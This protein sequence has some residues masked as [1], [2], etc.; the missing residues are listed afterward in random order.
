VTSRK[1]APQLPN[2]PT[3][4]EAGIPDFEATSW[5]AF[6]Y[7]TGTPRPIVDKLHSEVLKVVRLTDVKAT[8]DAQAFEVVGLGPDKFPEFVHSET[9][10]YERV[11]REAKIKVE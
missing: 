5:F 6:F 7:P 1:R 4:I 11:V 9:L 10:K 8:L 2:V 3:M